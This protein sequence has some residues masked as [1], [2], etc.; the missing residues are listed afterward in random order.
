M[1]SPWSRTAAGTSK[2]CREP[3]LASD[4][5][6]ESDYYRNYDEFLRAVG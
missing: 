4:E 5:Y 6:E 2:Q 1:F 3:A